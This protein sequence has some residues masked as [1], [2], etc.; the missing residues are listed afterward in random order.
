MSLV[1]RIEVIMA[2]G[3]Y[4]VRP[5]SRFGKGA[6]LASIA[7]AGSMVLSC[8]GRPVW[9][10]IL[11][12]LSIPLGLVGALR[13]ASP[14]VHGGFASIIAI[15]VGVLGIGVAIVAMVFKIVLF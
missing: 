11:A 10:L 5:P 3:N 12:L 13:A 14:E 9:G 2:N 8:S 15:V 7:S 4:S 1:P 6:L